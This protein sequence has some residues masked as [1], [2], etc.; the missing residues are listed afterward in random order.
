M[1]LNYEQYDMFLISKDNWKQQKDVFFGFKGI[2]TEGF[3]LQLKNN[4]NTLTIKGSYLQP[5]I[6][7]Y[8]KD[9]Y[10][11]LSNS[12]KVL[13]D[14]LNEKGIKLTDNKDYIS[15]ENMYIE[16][17][18]YCVNDYPETETRWNEIKLTPNFSYIEIKDDKL[19]IIETE[20]NLFKY[21]LIDNKT[22]VTNWFRKYYFHLFDRANKKTR[23]VGEISG[24]TD[25]RFLFN[26]WK[27]INVSKVVC[28][29][30]K[31]D[32]QGTF[33]DGLLGR[34]IVLYFSTHRDKIE[35]K[36]HIH[37]VTTKDIEK[38]ENELFYE[39]ISFSMRNPLDK[40]IYI[41]DQPNSLRYMTIS[42]VGSEWLKGISANNKRFILGTVRRYFI[43]KFIRTY[44]LKRVLTVLPYLDSS[45][46]TLKGFNDNTFLLTLYIKFCPEL[47]SLPFYTN[48]LIYQPTEYD[49]LQAKEI[50]GR[51]NSS[52]DL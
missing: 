37:N 18:G 5:A 30:N 52:E 10:W 50:I 24:G 29:W 4:G 11:V 28:N 36:L 46:L 26:F 45:L 6:A 32:Y 25:S 16:Y 21:D 12:V 19:N 23:I 49:M 51:W 13:T 22:L 34:L 2:G 35:S 48:G 44:Y 39:G 17:D 8:E 9:N 40:K 31:D 7:I 15:T 42:G 3:W 1:K 20:N 47:L 41:E 27:S 33:M 14:F 43:P 38:D